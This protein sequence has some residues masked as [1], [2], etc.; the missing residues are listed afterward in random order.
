MNQ[1]AHSIQ[2]ERLDPLLAQSRLGAG[3]EPLAAFAERSRALDASLK[4]LERLAGDAAARAVQKLRAELGRFEPAVTVLGQVKS[5]KTT[6]VNALAGWSDLLPADVNPWTSVVTSLHLIPGAQRKE[7]GARFQMMK[8]DEWDRLLTKG[9]RLGELAQRADAG[10]ELEKIRQQIEMMRDK[11][12][13]RLGKRFELLLGQEHEYGYFDRNLLERYICL[14]DDFLSQTDSAAAGKQGWFADIT[15]SAD[16]YLHCQSM[17][18]AMCIR[19]TPGVNDTFLMREQISIAAVRDSRVC[20]VVLSAHQ[21]LTSVD[22]GLIRMIS[23]LNARDVIIFVNR[24]DELQNPSV[25]IPEIARSIRE[26]LAAHQGPTEAEIIFGSANWANKA[27]SETIEDLTRASAAALVNW[28][29][30]AI[31]DQDLDLSPAEMVWRLSGLPA[32]NRAIASRMVSSLCEPHLRRIASA[33]VMIAGSLQAAHT[34]RVAGS[35]TDT[36]RS[37]PQITQM[38]GVLIRQQTLALTRDLAGITAA[39]HDRVDRAHAS[40]LERATHSL[41]THLEHHGEEVVWEYDP[42]GLRI[43]LKSAHSVY[44][45]RAQVAAVA[46]YRTAVEEVAELLYT[47]FGNCV[48]GIELAPPVAPDAPAP[49]SLAQTIVLDFN[50]GWWRSWWRRTRGYQA[51]SERF[52]A[53]ILAETQGFMATFRT[54]P[55]SDFNALL[56]GALKDFLDQCREIVAEIGNSGKDKDQVQ[57]LGVGTEVAGRKRM[58]ET[59]LTD[60]RD[61]VALT[62][63]D[64]T[65]P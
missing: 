52:H 64:V 49:V 24:V 60:L 39:Y 48:E 44:A 65:S 37:L 12:R 4:A 62:Q 31:P 28:A 10:G 20:V 16:L 22:M 53:M 46:R 50:D 2:A 5:G 61:Q 34:V 43:L 18:F 58:I 33:A 54:V 13:R 15:R 36:S 47:S 6:L 57:R 25:Q 9:G 8:A 21:A 32:L 11:S 23:N 3:L 56:E 27:Q 35:H 19:D 51:F 63:K 55:P 1:I 59:L 40:F 17:P 14:G 7:I 41:V 42:A 29:E 45:A 30:T 38:L 26:T